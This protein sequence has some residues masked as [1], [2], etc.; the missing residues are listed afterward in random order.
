MTCGVARPGSITVLD[1]LPRQEQL[2]EPFIVH[3]Q[4]WSKLRR[5]LAKQL[6]GR[7]RRLNVEDD[8][9]LDQTVESV[10]LDPIPQ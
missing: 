1:S 10:Q 2:I 7:E 5:H 3:V 6:L 8:A 4:P 9:A